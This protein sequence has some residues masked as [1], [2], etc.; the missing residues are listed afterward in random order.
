MNRATALG[1]GGGGGYASSASALAATA[2]FGSVAPGRVS[3]TFNLTGPSIAFDTACSSS[4]VAARSAA[5]DVGSGAGAA[6]VAGVNVMLAPNVTEV[7]RAAGMLSPSGR[8]K[9]LDATADGYVRGEDCRA[10]L[11]DSPTPELT[12][13]ASSGGGFDDERKNTNKNGVLIV[14]AAVNQDGRSSS[15]TAP[16]GPSQQ[17]VIR[18]AVFAADGSGG[19]GDAAWWFETTTTRV[20]QMHGTGTPL[21]DPIEVGAACAVFFPPVPASF[22]GREAAAN[23]DRA[24]PPPLVLESSKAWAGHAEPAAGTLGLVAL[25]DGFA[26]RA[27]RGLGCALRRLNPHVSAAAATAGTTT[28]SSSSTEIVVPIMA[29]RQASMLPSAARLNLAHQRGRSDGGGNAALVVG[30][31]SA[32]A[33]QG[34]NAHVWCEVGGGERR[35]GGGGGGAASN[36]RQPVSSAGVEAG[37]VVGGSR[38]AAT[39][40][41]RRRFW[42]SPLTHPLLT[43]AVI[44]G[45][46]GYRGAVVHFVAATEARPYIGTRIRST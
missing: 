22:S 46:G 41:H 19:G 33:F 2:S 26:T 38:G 31:V 29:S 34:T 37:H 10:F 3:F 23:D 39:V 43:S 1:S 15:L 44:N 32:F 25:C 5:L 8:C 40:M 17:A 36:K 6:V 12:T 21:G 9:T 28:K 30:G 35:G 20:L 16:N 13:T 24:P 45:D 11:F 18:S 27:V 4:L 42:A 7:F 14:G